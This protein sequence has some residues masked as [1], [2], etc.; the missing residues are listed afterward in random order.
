[1]VNLILGTCLF[2]GYGQNMID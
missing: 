1:M 2:R